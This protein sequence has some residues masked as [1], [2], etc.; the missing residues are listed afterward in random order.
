MKRMLLLA[1]IVIC[2]ACTLVAFSLLAPAA[3]ASAPDVVII[4]AGGTPFEEAAKI[5][6]ANVDAVSCPTPVARNC[7]SV[8]EQV[9]EALRAKNLDVRVAATDDIKDRRELL[10]PRLVVLASPCYYGNVSWRMH[11]LID[12]RLWQIFALGG[13]RLAGHPYA[14]LAIGRTEANAKGAAEFL[15]GC[16]KSTNGKVVGAMTVGAD[17]TD[18]QVKERVAAFTETVAGALKEVK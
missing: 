5:T 10:A 8:A 17:N 11:K 2:A 12:E 1:C 15:Q 13:E 4:Q 14:V 3:P 16:V 9:A 7:K 6:A 18:D